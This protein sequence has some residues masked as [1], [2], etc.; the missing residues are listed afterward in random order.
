[1]MAVVM[2]AADVTA[3]VLLAVP[4]A[5]LLLLLRSAFAHIVYSLQRSAILKALTAHA[6]P[7]PGVMW[8]GGG[9]EEAI[10]IR[11]THIAAALRQ[12][13][14]I[15][16]APG[17]KAIKGA[18][19]VLEN[20]RQ[21]DAAQM[22]GSTVKSIRKYQ[23]LVAKVLATASSAATIAAAAVVLGPTTAGLVCG[24]AA[25]AV[26]P[27]AIRSL[28][29]VTNVSLK[30]EIHQPLEGRTYRVWCATVKW[31]D[32]TENQQ[33]TQPVLHEPAPQEETPDER[34]KR[35]HREH[36][37]LIRALR[38]LDERAVAEYR[39][40]DRDRKRAKAAQRLSRLPALPI[41][42]GDPAWSAPLGERPLFV[43]EHVWLL[44]SDASAPPQ[45]ATIRGLW[46]DE[47]VDITVQQTQERMRTTSDRLVTLGAR[48]PSYVGQRVSLLSRPCTSDLAMIT[49]V[50]DDGTLDV[51]LFNALSGQYDGGIHRHLIAMAKP[52]TSPRITSFDSDEIQRK[53]VDGEYCSQPLYREWVREPCKC[54]TPP[55]C[56]GG[57]RISGWTPGKSDV[58]VQVFSPSAGRYEDHTG[59]ITAL[60]DDKYCADITLQNRA[61]GKFD[62][63]VHRCVSL[64]VVPGT[65]RDVYGFS[66]NQQVTSIVELPSD[67]LDVAVTASIPALVQS[68]LLMN[69]SAI[70]QKRSR[71]DP[72]AIERPPKILRVADRMREWRQTKLTDSMR[73]RRMPACSFTGARM[74]RKLANW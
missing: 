59:L 47:S 18:I 35:E 29:N 41:P 28:P 63:P 53:L 42:E 60:H 3:V 65:N 7:T 39:V 68:F 48:V 72:L 15:V 13:G 57:W 50:H 26:M 25:A 37:R 11:T 61:S 44:S 9:D 69:E 33:D 56:H 1:M 5:S 43:G 31:A 10:D 62:G 20:H 8:G 55:S 66:R 22:S 46:R 64:R 71:D 73:L 16:N 40:K 70:G 45:L 17:L 38:A 12:L 23:P 51:Q 58:Q 36:E 6:Q 30:S 52:D 4:T 32:G 49:A 2:M 24:A 74:K 21:T 27:P 54:C 19:L 67:P 34:R 14:E